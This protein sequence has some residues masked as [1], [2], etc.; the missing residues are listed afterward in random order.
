MAGALAIITP[1]LLEF[2]EE[3]G[4]DWL[5]WLRGPI[6]APRDVVVVSIDSES[7]TAL[8]LPLDP[9]EWP[10]SLYAEA[11]E[12]L[13]ASGA[14]VTAVD[15]SFREARDPGQ[16]QILANSIL[17]AGNVLLL[18]WTVEP[19]TGP[20]TRPSG[21]EIQQRFPPIPLLADAALGSAP[22][23]LPLDPSKVS[24]FWAFGRIDSDR[25]MLPSAAI[26]AFALDVHDEFLDLVEAVRPG[27][28]ALLPRRAELSSGRNL[29]SAGRQI[30]RLFLGD[31]EL[32]ADLRDYVA[33]LRANQSPG[34]SRE[35]HAT[36]VDQLIGL[37]GGPEFLHLN[38]YGPP[39]SITTIPYVHMRAMN[40]EDARAAFEGKIVFFGVSEPGTSLQDDDVETPFT[41]EGTKLNGVEIGA[42]A[43]ANLL[44]GRFVIPVPRLLLLPILLLWGSALVGVLLWLPTRTGILTAVFAG[45][46]YVFMALR[47]FETNG[48]WLPV[49]APVFG[50]IPLALIAAFAWKYANEQRQR[51]RVQRT[52]EVY[53]PKPALEQFSHRIEGALP[54]ARLL[55]GICMVT[56]AQNYTALA[57]RLP[58]QELQKT[59][60][61]YY[62]VL[63]PEVERLEGF[64]AD[65][66]G[67]SMVAVWATPGPESTARLNACRAAIAIERS[68]RAFNAAHPEFPLPTRI[69]I[70]AG[71]IL[72]GN[73]G[74]ESHRE[75]RPI[76]DIVNTASRIQDF[77]KQLRTSLLVSED[78][79]QDVGSVSFRRLGAFL[80][81]GK[82]VPIR[83][84]DRISFA[85]RPE[86]EHLTLIAAFEEAHRLFLGR[87]WTEA[88]AAF[89][90][91]LAGHPADGPSEFYRTL[92][93][94]FAADDPGPLWTGTVGVA[95]N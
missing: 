1:K 39:R 2:E 53:L 63:F 48:I 43:V 8:G 49:V 47:L 82:G 80:L 41:E 81:A 71:E 61:A 18:E 30:R 66:I 89:E 87:R 23:V 12:R 19:S 62:A 32:S 56:D 52:L 57:E 31:P 33:T 3:A 79:L 17:E 9:E 29:T 84:C 11:I 70:H 55:H 68:T 14:K 92:C 76:G 4:L 27:S 74:T 26:H 77:N 20:G 67:D 36:L 93:H 46:A 75:Y 83:L 15:L 65:V 90:S 40:R 91:L 58:P 72:L 13:D 35:R 44:E 42:T 25:P 22:F 50:Q 7:A 59:L 37:Y 78:V 10:R 51:D 95:M 45:A 34:Q 94:R 21:L 88:A 6:E 60:N 24:R 64:V 86:P 54:D 85:A 69:G 28:T 5:F 73:V 16:D 38:F